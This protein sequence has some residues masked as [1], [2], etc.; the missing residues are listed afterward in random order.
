MALNEL[1]KREK[2]KEETKTELHQEKLF[3]LTGFSL[4]KIVVN[5]SFSIVGIQPTYTKATG[6]Q[7]Y[8]ETINL[9]DLHWFP[10][11]LCNPAS[12]ECSSLL[13][14][15]LKKKHQ[16]IPREIPRVALTKKPCFKHNASL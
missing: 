5:D 4:L 2:K 6:D 16:E 7:F 12:Y 9:P 1:K 13:Y 3:I 10:P 14:Y 11:H 8:P 15:F